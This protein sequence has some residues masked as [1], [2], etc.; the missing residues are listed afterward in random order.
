MSRPKK[1]PKKPLTRPKLKSD[2][3]EKYN[4]KWD[5]RYYVKIYQFACQG[6]SDK[7]ISEAMNISQDT[8]TAWKKKR[9]ALREALKQARSD[10]R[11]DLDTFQNYVHRRLPPDLQEL[12]DEIHELEKEE[13]GYQLIE[14]LLENGG[15]RVRQWLFLRALA[16][17][18]TVTKACKRVNINRITFNRW[19]SEPEFAAIVSEIHEAKK[20]LGE[21]AL[22]DLVRQRDTS[23]VLFFNRTLNKDRGYSPK[24]ELEHG[25]SIDHR[26]DVRVIEID[27]LNLP[28]ELR[29]E[30]LERMREQLPPEDQKLIEYHGNGKETEE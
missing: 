16:G 27:K 12:W 20:D 7:A 15:V 19:C 24:I 5:D 17:S 13:C 14:N 10:K 26:H 25:G 21:N 3:R 2:L 23:A 29:R 1:K 8:M 22:L 11:P 28:I 30:L 4:Y 6:Y 9:P 18:L